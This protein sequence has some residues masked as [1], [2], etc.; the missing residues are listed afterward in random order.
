MEMAATAPTAAA[1][2]ALVIGGGASSIR[3]KTAARI[4][5][6]SIFH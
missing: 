1:M 6:T 3:V 4:S 2:A 5:K